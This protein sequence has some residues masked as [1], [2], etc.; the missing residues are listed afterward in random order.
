MI[1]N[2]NTGI[3]FKKRTLEMLQDTLFFEKNINDAN[4]SDFQKCYSE[5]VKQFTERLGFQSRD[6]LMESLD[7]I[8]TE[9]FWSQINFL[10]EEIQK[11]VDNKMN[12]I[13]ELF[14]KSDEIDNI[15]RVFFQSTFQRIRRMIAT[16]RGENVKIVSEILYRLLILSVLYKYRNNSFKEA[17]L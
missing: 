11:R 8:S 10:Y 12:T 6:D 14:F 4:L 16:A 3:D 9:D 17:V 7:S 1:E 13:T 2:I 15:S 5:A